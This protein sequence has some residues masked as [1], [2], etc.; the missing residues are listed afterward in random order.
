MPIGIAGMDLMTKLI[1]FT[2]AMN[3]RLTR[4]L[5][6][7]L[8]ISPPILVPSFSAKKVAAAIHIPATKNDMIT[9]VK[10]NESITKIYNEIK[11]EAK[12]KNRI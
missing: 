9:L 1:S 4:M 7:R 5:E 12:L 11:Y 2:C 10:N 6:G 8:V 3:I